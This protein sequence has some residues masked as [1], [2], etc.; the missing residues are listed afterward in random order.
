MPFY[1]YAWIASFSSACIIITTKLTSKYSIKNP[2]F[3]TFLW[4][5]IIMVFTVPSSLLHHAGLPKDW[6]PI[7]W[8]SLFSAIWNF[9]YIKTIYSIDVSTLSPIFNFRTVFAVILGAIFFKEQL[10]AY[11]FLLFLVIVIAGMFASLDEKMNIKLFFKPAIFIA[12]LAMLALT[13]NNLLI[14]SALVHNDIWTANLWM[15]VITFLFLLPTLPLFMKEMRKINLFQILS[16]GLMGALQTVTN[17]GANIAYGVNVGIT[18]LIMAVP[19]SLIITFLLAMFIPTLLEKHT[20]KV[21]AIRFGAAIVM[22]IAALQ[23]SA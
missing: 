19:V 3:F 18:S 11:Q 12:L 5:L 6:S 22:I 8:A 21:Y 15:S 4:I 1:I 16:V 7:I 20:V 23:L 2:W 9:L 14:K 10:T 13:I 17:W